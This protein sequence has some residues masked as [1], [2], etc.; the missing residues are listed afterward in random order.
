MHRKM[1]AVYLI[2]RTVQSK[3]TYVKNFYH[4][5]NGLHCYASVRPHDN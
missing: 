1:T 3:T 4:S 2:A 5:I